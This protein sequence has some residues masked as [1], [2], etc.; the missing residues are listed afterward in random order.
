MF[1]AGRPFPEWDHVGSKSPSSGLAALT[2]IPPRGKAADIE[3]WLLRKYREDLTE[4]AQS[5]RRNMTKEERHLWYDFLR[6][7][8][9]RFRR[10]KPIGCYILDFYCAEV[11]LAV[12]LDGSQHFEEAGEA[13][14]KDRTRYLEHQGIRVLRFSNRELWENFDGVRMAIYLAAGID[15][16]K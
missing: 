1:H 5:L 9:Y 2:H 6:T 10:Q 16:D 11:R 3:V 4:K 7:F 14:D 8:P 13:Y 12:E 15:K